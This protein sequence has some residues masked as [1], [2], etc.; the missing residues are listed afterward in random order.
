VTPF[1]LCPWCGYRLARIRGHE[2][3][4]QTSFRAGKGSV[5]LC[6]NPVCGHERERSDVDLG[7]AY[8]REQLALALAL[9]LIRSRPIPPRP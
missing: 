6:R 1:V 2:G 8:W 7:L 9:R 5:W 4:V 3:T